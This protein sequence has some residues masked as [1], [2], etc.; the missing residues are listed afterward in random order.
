MACLLVLL[1]ICALPMIGG[2]QSDKDAAHGLPRASGIGMGCVMT[3][4]Y[5]YV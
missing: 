2:P 3:T 1:A 4:A 5:L